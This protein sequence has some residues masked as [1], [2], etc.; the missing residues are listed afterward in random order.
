MKSNNIQTLRKLSVSEM[1]KELKA[2]EETIFKLRFQKVVE[3][4][5][6]TSQIRKTKKKI[7]QLQTL[8]QAQPKQ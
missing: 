8:L 2:A 5:G 6:D 1:E 7:A 4:V 3:E